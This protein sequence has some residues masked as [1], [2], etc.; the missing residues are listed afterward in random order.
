MIAE[1]LIELKDKIETRKKEQDKLKWELEENVKKLKELGC[2]SVEIA[3]EKLKEINID[4]E[5]R[6]TLLNE[7]IAKAEELLND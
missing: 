2:D 3:Q 7:K 1:K 6:T 5:K 4:I